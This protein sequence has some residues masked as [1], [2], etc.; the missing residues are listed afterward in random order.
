[1]FGLPCILGRITCFNT[2][3]S[4]LSIKA[5]YSPKYTRQP[6]IIDPSI[7]NV[8]ASIINELEKRGLITK[9]VKVLGVPLY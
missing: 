8:P 6:A 3:M 4:W 2:C 5:S 7:G 1:M 9:S